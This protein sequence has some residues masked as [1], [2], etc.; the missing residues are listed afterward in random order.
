MTTIYNLPFTIFKNKIKVR[1]G[2][3][4]LPLTPLK[5]I[6]FSQQH[7]NVFTGKQPLWENIR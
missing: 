7:K 1:Y 6:A 3:N 5:Q 2:Y 4:K